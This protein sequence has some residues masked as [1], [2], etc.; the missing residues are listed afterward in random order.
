VGQGVPNQLSI[1]DLNAG[2]PSGIYVVFQPTT[3]DAFVDPFGRLAPAPGTV[4]PTPNVPS[5][6]VTDL[7]NRVLR[8]PP[9]NEAYLFQNVTAQRLRDITGFLQYVD[10]C[11]EII[12]HTAAGTQL[13]ANINAAPNPVF[14]SPATG[15]NQTFAGDTSY[16]NTLTDA[17]LNFVGGQLMPVANIVAMVNQR[18]VGINGALARFNQLAAD[19]NNLPL[20]SLFQPVGAVPTFLWTHFRFNGLRFT[21]QN[22]MNWLS[23]AGYA[24]FDHNVRTLPTVVQG[25]R[26]REAFLLAMNIVL[27]S[28]APPG[29]GT[30]AGVKFN[31]RNEGDNLLGGAGFR[32]PAV[33]LAHELMHAMHYGHGTAAGYDFGHFTTT[34]AEL[35]FVG[36]GTFAAQPITENA[37]RG[38]WGAIPGGAID[39]SNVWAAP[40]PRTIYDAPVLP[41]TP[42]S[43]RGQLHCI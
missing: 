35:L 40:A 33:G 26:V 9:P 1:F 28:A 21:G 27:Y 10:T 29:I 8:N 20:C 6:A 41:D 36:I 19:M 15:G 39:P 2:V 25:V 16:V 11:L 7:I 5:Q 23:P 17:I 43:L 13:L 14:I 32:P 24:L 22:L 31:V 3:L 12:N 42:T 37:V 18:Y 30:G 4:Y 34:A 38:Q